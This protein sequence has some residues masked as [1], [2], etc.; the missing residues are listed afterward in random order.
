MRTIPG[1]Y[2]VDQNH[3]SFSD[4]VSAIAHKGAR[5]IARRLHRGCARA[6][7]TK[8]S[9]F[10]RTSFF[11]QLTILPHFSAHNF[12]AATMSAVRELQAMS[13][14]DLK[15]FAKSRGLKSSGKKDEI[16]QHILNQT[17]ARRRGRPAG[18]GISKSPP[19]TLGPKE[20]FFKA[21]RLGVMQKHGKDKDEVNAHLELL[22]KRSQKME[23]L[24]KED[25]AKK[26]E[27][28]EV[29]LLAT[30]KQFLKD[31]IPQF[32]ETEYI[33]T[34]LNNNYI[35]IHEPNGDVMSKDKLVE[36]VA[37][38]FVG[39]DDDEDEPEAVEAML[40]TTTHDDNQSDSCGD[41]DDEDDEDDDDE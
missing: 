2:R 21:N 25:K 27:D 15:R 3:V 7:P 28:E 26:E 37:E 29:D 10:S 39:D 31:R 34:L 30:I 4:L 12:H 22:W 6:L 41:D 24:K 9:K 40:A 17:K 13:V 14:V 1:A 19:S 11:L 20:L 35:E 16:M 8:C 18:G 38:M 32:M 33:K 23:K 5:Q 36:L